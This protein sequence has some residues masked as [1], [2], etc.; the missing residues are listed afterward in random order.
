MVNA[1]M[2]RKVRF[3]LAAVVLA[4]FGAAVGLAQE[5]NEDE[6]DGATANESIKYAR[7]AG[8][9]ALVAE[10]IRDSVLMLAAAILDE[11]ADV[12]VVERGKANDP[13]GALGEQK[14][15]ARDLFELAE[16]YA[17]ENE[18]MLALVR[19]SV[20]RAA[21]MS[22]KGRVH[23]AAVHR[24]RVLAYDTDIYRE[25][26]RAKELAEI[27]IVGDGDTDLD[28]YI[29]DENG[30]LICEDLGFTDRAYCTWTPR[31]EG[32]FEI[33]VENLGNVYNEYRLF[34]N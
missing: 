32:I 10:E 13:Q 23:G 17:G 21:S 3:V 12:A 33:H 25:V 16:E 19:D 24:D 6:K 20:S 8:E 9:L 5:L 27:C 11:M 1:I 15:L 18:A 7:L 22:M 14:P 31:W 34:T 4:G 30:N 2:A 28:L 29:Y 26:Y